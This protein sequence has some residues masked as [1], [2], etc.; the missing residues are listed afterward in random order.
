M[1]YFLLGF[2]FTWS[3][4]AHAFEQKPK[5]TKLNQG[6]KAPF[7]GRLFNDAAVSKLIVENRLMVEKC[8]IQIGYEVKKA[9]EREKYNYNLLSAK[10]EAAADYTNDILS[11]KQDEINK[12]NKLIK[13]N[14]NMW[15]L[16]GGFM[17]GVGTSIAIMHAVK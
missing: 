4:A 16:S 2:L 6:Q 9:V 3:S 14:R 13:P 7:E 1:K 11:I 10:C 17:A 12:L 5:F 15:W 8:D